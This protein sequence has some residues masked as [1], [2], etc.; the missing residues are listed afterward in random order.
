MVSKIREGIDNL[1][2]D[3]L[4]KDDWLFILSYSALFLFIGLI[5]G[6]VIGFL[7]GLIGG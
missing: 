7:I 5:I 3:K 2:V 6:V 1:R 4:R